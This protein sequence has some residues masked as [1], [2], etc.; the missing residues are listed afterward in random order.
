MKTPCS[1]EQPRGLDEDADDF[2]HNL[3]TWTD[4]S[5]ARLVVLYLITEL[6]FFLSSILIIPM[7]PFLI[8]H[9]LKQ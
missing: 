4:Q 9:T 3:F 5:N 2:S 6:I 1:D 7:Y 8:S